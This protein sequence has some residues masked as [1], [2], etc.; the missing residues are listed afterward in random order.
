M[1]SMAGS[2]PEADFKGSPNHWPVVFTIYE[3]QV[4]NFASTIYMA[5]GRKY[6]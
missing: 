6:K 5:K 4:R 2:Q 1:D 3:L